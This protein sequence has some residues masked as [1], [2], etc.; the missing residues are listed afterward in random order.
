MFPIYE[1][2]D[3]A[4][5]LMQHYEHI[6][7]HRVNHR[8]MLL[9]CIIEDKYNQSIQGDDDEGESVDLPSGTMGHIAK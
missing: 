4:M 8:L 9:D 1:G 2:I 5:A 7:V 3:D 6:L